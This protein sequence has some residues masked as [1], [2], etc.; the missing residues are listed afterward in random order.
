MLNWLSRVNFHYGPLAVLTITEF[1]KLKILIIL[2]ELLKRSNICSISCTIGIIF[3]LIIMR[4]YI[5]FI[6]SDLPSNCHQALLT[7]LS[8]TWPW[9][10]LLSL[11]GDNK[12]IFRP[13]SAVTGRLIT[14]QKSMSSSMSINSEVSSA[15]NQQLLT[16]WIFNIYLQ[17]A[18][19]LMWFC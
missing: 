9:I 2:R 12:V 19:T 8:S 6:R 3:F 18:W 4:P 15:R 11:C 17:V 14:S 5:I 13:Q 16:Q 10:P 7:R 1:L